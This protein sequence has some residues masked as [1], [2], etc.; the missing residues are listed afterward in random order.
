MIHSIRT[1]F[2]LAVL[3]LCATATDARAAKPEEYSPSNPPPAS[4]AFAGPV[5]G[6]VDKD[7][8]GTVFF[9]YV[10]IIHSLQPTR[11]QV[12]DA[13]SG[14]VLVDDPDP[15]LQET[16]YKHPSKPKV[17]IYQWEG[18]SPVEIITESEPGW[19]HDGKSTAVNLEIRLFKGD[20]VSFSFKQSATYSGVVKTQIL[21]AVEYNKSFDSKK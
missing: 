15:S 14:A 2:V 17:G 18:R 13:D 19:L 20:K 5:G 12:L 11:V 6:M 1:G 10:A 7:G 8:N 21:H 16:P 4:F 3:G 9:R